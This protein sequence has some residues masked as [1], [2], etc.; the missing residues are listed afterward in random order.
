[1][2]GFFF[3]LLPPAMCASKRCPRHPNKNA[4]AITALMCRSP[5]WKVSD[6]M[7]S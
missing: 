3:F 2:R 6:G 4:R 1:M 5:E 7:Y